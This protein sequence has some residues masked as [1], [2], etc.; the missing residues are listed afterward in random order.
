MASYFLLKTNL[1]KLAAKTSISQVILVTCPITHAQ[2]QKN[3]G[4][5]CIPRLN[6]I[7]KSSY[8]KSLTYFKKVA[9]LNLKM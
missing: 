6:A 2:N 9:S 5:A 7:S 3:Q 1:R 4:F 8:K